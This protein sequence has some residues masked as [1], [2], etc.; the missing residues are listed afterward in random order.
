MAPGKTL[1]LV[2]LEGTGFYLCNVTVTIPDGFTNRELADAVL[3]GITNLG[4]EPQKVFPADD[5]EY[6]GPGA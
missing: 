1:T 2:D 4:R 6:S 5:G 3:E